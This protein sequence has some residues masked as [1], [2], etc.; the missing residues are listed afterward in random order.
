MHKL[1][2]SDAGIS[3]VE[4]LLDLGAYY[5]FLPGEEKDDLNK[6]MN[7]TR[8]AKEQSLKLN[9]SDGYIESLCLEGHIL[10][11]NEQGD[12]SKPVLDSAILSVSAGIVSNNFI[13]LIHQVTNVKRH[14][15]CC[16]KTRSEA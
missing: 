8:K 2:N 7:Y 5:L 16:N 14:F 6:A 9:F 4:I 12:Q 1:S 11:E 13:A 15:A 3:H 10:I